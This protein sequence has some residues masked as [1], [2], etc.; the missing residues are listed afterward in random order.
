MAGAADDLLS[1]IRAYGV[2]SAAIYVGGGL[3]YDNRDQELQLTRVYPTLAQALAAA[4]AIGRQQWVVFSWRTD[5]SNRLEV[6]RS[7]ESS[8]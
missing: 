4:Q 6:V 7:S 3:D 5:A 2:E 1:E 8:P